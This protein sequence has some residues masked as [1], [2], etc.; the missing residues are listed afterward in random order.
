[1]AKLILSLDSAV[2]REF[3]LEKDITTVG[4]KPHND[5]QIDNLAVSGEH[6]RICRVGADVFAEDMQSTNGTM[7]N[8]QPIQRQLLQDGDLVEIGRY[9]LKFISEAAPRPAM[10][11]A[12][13]EKTMVIR[14]GTVKPMSPSD[15]QQIPVMAAPAPAPA[16][17][18]TPA[19]TATTDPAVA[20]I[21]VLTG[22]NAG[23]TLDLVKNITSLGKPGVQVAIITRRPTGYFITHVEG[24]NR[25]TLNGTQIGLQAEALNS[26]DIIELAGVKM[27]FSSK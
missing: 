25:P 5:L 20:Q 14:P 27:E 4:R 17:A 10:D 22:G 16:P 2:L 7:V 15:T 24:P 19:P 6:A 1:M 8:G 26:G 11:P 21:K 3:K 13:F 12:D 9:K 23:K 18:P